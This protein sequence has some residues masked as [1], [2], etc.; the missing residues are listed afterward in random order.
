MK[1]EAVVSMKIE[2]EA[3]IDPLGSRKVE[4]DDST[5]QFLLENPD[6]T[7]DLSLKLLVQTAVQLGKTEIEQCT[8]ML[9]ALNELRRILDEEF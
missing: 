3:D 2:F 9:Q 4:F 1:D 6:R 8:Y 7:A 5:R